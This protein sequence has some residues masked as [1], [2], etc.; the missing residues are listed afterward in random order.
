MADPLNFQYTTLSLIRPVNGGSPAFVP[1]SITGTGSDSSVAVSFNGASFNS[2]YM[3]N[4][5]SDLRSTNAS[6]L[7]DGPVTVYTK[8]IDWI[9]SIT[10]GAKV[11][12]LS[13][14]IEG[15]YN[16]N[17]NVMVRDT[18]RLYLRNATNPFAV[19]DSSKAYLSPA[20]QASFIFNHA[21]NSVNYY[22]QIIHRNA[23][24]TW[25]KTAIQFT[26]NHVSYD[27]TNNANK[28]FGNNMQ[29]SGTRYV[30]YEG[31]VNHDG[32]VDLNDNSLIE[33][34]AYNFAS[35]Y[36][37]TDLNGDGIVDLNDQ[38]I[39]DNNS[40]NFVGK[41]TPLSS[42][43]VLARKGI[44]LENYLRENSQINPL[45]ISEGDTRIDNEIYERFK[46]ETAE[47]LRITDFEI[48]VKGRNERI[49]RK[50]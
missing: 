2:F 32:T 15:F 38:S 18:I 1:K 3:S 21:S 14:L 26:A 10:T 9:Q 31:D 12:D 40:Y 8:I 45:Q 5:F 29:L 16:P 23:V 19:V 4:R 30:I 7:I 37:R 11:L 20:G 13:V 47:P 44:V 49:V 25:S 28:A 43:V 48:I 33:N 6:P 41:I 46:N 42:P 17:T 39:A 35:G 24:E 27:F 22:L 36:I 50:K 34:D